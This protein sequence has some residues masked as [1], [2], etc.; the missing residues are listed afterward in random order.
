MTAQKNDVYTLLR[1]CAPKIRNET[2]ADNKAA[3]ECKT[4]K[5]LTRLIIEVPEVPVASVRHTIYA[6]R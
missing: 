4:N 5:L 2:A 3:F 6:M 1:G